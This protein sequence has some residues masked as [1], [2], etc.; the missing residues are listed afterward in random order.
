MVLR[1]FF[2]SWSSQ[3]WADFYI[4]H[5][6]LH[7]PQ[8]Q[9]WMK[10]FVSNIW[11]HSIQKYL[12]DSKEGEDITFDQLQGKLKITEQNYLLPIWSGLN[13]PTIFLKRLPNVLRINNY[14]SAC[15]SAWR[16]N[17]DIQFVLDVYACAML[18]NCIIHF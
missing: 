10:Y 7:Y 9:N 5:S 4:E 2:K 6:E 16:E 8:M 12:N 3:I 14:N 18:C 1:I 11:Y 13:A 17:M 15:L